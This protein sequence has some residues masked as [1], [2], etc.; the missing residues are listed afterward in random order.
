MVKV[1]LVTAVAFGLALAGPARGEEKPA[2]KEEAKRPED[3]KQAKKIS[4]EEFEKLR[5]KEGS[6]VV[7]VRT[8][9]EYANGH[10]PGAVNVPLQSE[11]FDK[12]VKAMSKDKTYLVYCAVGGR[13]AKASARMK[14]LGVPNVLDFTGS[15]RAWREAEKPVEQGK[16]EGEK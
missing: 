8:P 9:A 13:S 12:R 15:M 1:I 16:P 10:V 5:E 2:K 6:V 11:D 4:L 3:S 14:E 7:D